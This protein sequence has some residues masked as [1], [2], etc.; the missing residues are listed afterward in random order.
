MATTSI[1]RPDHGRAAT[2]AALI[3]TLLDQLPPGHPARAT[4]RKLEKLYQRR[5]VPLEELRE[6]LNRVPGKSMAQK[7]ERIGIP[8]GSVWA[9]WNG[10]YVPS[11]EVLD[12]ILAEAGWPE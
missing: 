4:A 3:A 8:K 12:R 7:G 6:M 9:I 10:K 1:N 11:Q 2:A 5:G